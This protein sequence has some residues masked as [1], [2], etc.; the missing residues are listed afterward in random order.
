MKRTILMTS[1]CLVTLLTVTMFPGCK[2]T[3]PRV[4]SDESKANSYYQLGLAALNQGDYAR[5]RREITRAIN[6]APDIAHYHNHLGLVYYHT[7]DYKRSEELY[8]KA[9]SLDRSYSDVYNNLGA[10]Y[11][12]LGKLEK[13]VEYFEKV[14]EDPLYP[15]PHFAHT[16]L[17]IVRRMEK[18]FED[19]KR[20]LNDALRVKGTHCEAYKELGIIYDEQSLFDKAFLNYQKA[21]QFCP[22][23]VE[24]LYRGAVRAYTLK[25]ESVGAMYLERCL[26]V[27]FSN[28]RRVQ[29]PFLEDCVNL[30]KSI[31]VEFVP[32][33]TSPREGPK[34][35]IDAN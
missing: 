14:I 5:A 29:I 23:H 26:E 6:T 24:A 22:Y 34:R 16:N 28:I 1:F 15:Y 12:R 27:D 13:A 4:V 9:L 10:L 3:E 21:I 33:T 17:G 35:Q 19:A 11:I 20:H 30:A 32:K 31:G 8:R 18:R 2:T 25:K 7:G